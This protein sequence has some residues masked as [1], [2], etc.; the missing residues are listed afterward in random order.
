MLK[1]I[2]PSKAEAL[3]FPFS[4]AEIYAALMGINGD[5]APSPDGFTVV[6]WQSC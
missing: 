1:Q 5:K 6:F 3:E 2:S 4:E